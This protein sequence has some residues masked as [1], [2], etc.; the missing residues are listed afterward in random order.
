VRVG[1]TITLAICTNFNSD[2]SDVFF[3]DIVK[4]TKF[5][6]EAFLTATY[7]INRLPSK[8]SHDLTPLECLFEHRPDYSFLHTF[9]CACWPHHHPYNTHKLQSRSK[10]CVFLGY[11]EMHKGYKCL[12]VSTHRIYVSRNVIFDE[13]SFPF[14]ELNSNAG[15]RLRSEIALLHPTL[16][17]HNRGD[18]MMHDCISNNPLATKMVN[19]I[20][21]G[22]LEENHDQNGLQQEIAAAA[23][24]EGNESTSNSM[25]QQSAPEQTQSSP[26]SMR[27]PGVVI[28]QG[29][30]KSPARATA[31]QC[32]S[33]FVC[34]EQQ[35]V[36]AEQ[37]V[38]LDSMR[39]E[40]PRSGVVAGSSAEVV[41]T[42]ASED[43][44]NTGPTTRAK[45]GIHRPWVYTDGTVR[46]GKHGFLTHSGEPYSIDDALVDKNWKIAMDSE[47]DALMK[48]KTWH[49]V[50]LMKGRNVVG[51]KWVYKIKRKQDGNLDRYKVRLVAK[52]FKQRYVIDYED[53]FSPVV[54]I[55]T[56][57]IILSIVVSKGWSL[58]QFDVQNA[59]LHGYLEEEVYMQQPPGYEDT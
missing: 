29:P 48:N 8:V 10:R 52:G 47:Y 18:I 37:V 55:A 51:C 45:K 57:H 17:P 30:D 40:V 1:H 32:L 59:F 28:A 42:T 36:R 3:L 12:E 6:D 50:P 19:E 33:E 38:A 9:G 49:L 15:A 7:L 43:T 25:P 54:K 16:L 34:S 27:S 5:W 44:R 11:S 35:P 58:R 53:T 20:A 4:C 46:Y 56:I 41:A 13:E 14:S 22:N 23:A 24:N 26:G 2:P 39:T 21:G 31:A